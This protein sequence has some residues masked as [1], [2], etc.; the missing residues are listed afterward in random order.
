MRTGLTP[1]PRESAIAL[2]LVTSTAG[3]QCPSG[4]LP[5]QGIPG[6]DGEVRAA[7]E[8]DPDGPGPQPALLIVGGYFEL[9]GE[10]PAK[11]VA[12]WDGSAWHNLGSGVNGAISAL[13]VYNGKLIAGGFFS[14]AG[15]TSAN[16]IA[17]W[18]GSAW[19]PLGSGISDQVLSLCVY[20]GALIAGGSFV[21][22]GGLSAGSIASWNGSDWEALGSG[23]SSGGGTYVFA[24]TAFN[25][26]LVAGGSFTTAGGVSASNIA[27]WNGSA[28]QALGAGTNLYVQSLAVYDGELIAG[29]TF[30]TA[31]AVDAAH[32][33]RWDGSAWHILGDGIG[34]PLPFTAQVLAL[35]V[36]DGQLFAGGTFPSA[37]GVAASNIAAWDGLA[38]KPLGSGANHWVMGLTVFNGELIAAGG[39]GTAGSTGVNGVARWDGSTWHS[40]GSGTNGNVYSFA[41]FDG[42]LIAGGVFT[43][44]EGVDV[45]RLARWDGTAWQPLIGGGV[46]GPIGSPLGSWVSALAVDNGSLVVGGFFSAAGEI[47][48]ENIARWDGLSWHNLGSGIA[49][50][51]PIPFIGA[52]AVYNGDLIAGGR[53]DTAGGVSAANIARWDGS[54]WH[55]LGSGISGV[56]GNTHVLALAVYDGKLIAG[57][58]FTTAGGVPAQCIAS[59]DGSTWQPLPS[60][61]YSVSALELFNGDLIAGGSFASAGGVSASN[62]ARW[63]GSSWHALGSGTSGLVGALAVHDGALIAGG[64][65]ETAGGTAAHFI[66]RWD[67]SAWESMGGG[68]DWM[69]YSVESYG[70]GV[71]G[72]LFAGGDFTTV[73]GEISAH[74]AHFGALC[75]PGDLDE[76]GDVDLEDMASLLDEW[77][78]CPVPCPPACAGDVNGDCEV[79]IVDFLTLLSNW[80]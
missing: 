66:A 72:Q 70:A 57:G 3:A 38:W 63:D 74:L 33:A 35:A 50:G 65:F 18:D 55:P 34:D 54:A 23:M 4:W 76:D 26:E 62:I 49:G 13:A 30:T 52:M 80:K 39:M 32:V 24:V 9:A 58:R 59:W 56:P 45:E 67:G 27:R 71:T 17:R 10:V 8:W 5:G 2:V 77:G 29:G 61:M 15:G 42:A 37:G 25:G 19:Q 40:L 69:V 1:R 6:V 53:F 11:N 79:N 78:P 43:S 64:L 60:G 48:V 73:D 7:V 31:G 14:N 46:N 28:W 41:V 16:S 21:T 51:E 36:D 75:S 68:M 12:A 20:D 22:A 47:P 44:V